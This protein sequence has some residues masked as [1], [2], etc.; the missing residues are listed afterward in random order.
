MMYA[1]YHTHTTFCDGKNTPEEMVLGAIKKGM[2]AIGF[3]GHSYLPGGE[4]YCMLKENIPAYRTEILRLK[5]VY[6]DKIQ[7]LLGLEQEYFSPHTPDG[8][9]YVIG[10]AHNLCKDGK[11][12][13]VD[14]TCEAL[15]QGVNDLF[16][17]D[18]YAAAENYFEIVA[19]IPHKW[20]VDVIGHFDLITKF[21]EGQTLFD[22]SHPRYEKAAKAALD[23]LLLYDIPIEV[24][25]GAMSRGYRT[26]PYPA[27][28][29]LSYIAQKG[30]RV[31]LNGDSH[32]VESLCHRF[33]DVLPM[34]QELGLKVEERP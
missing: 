10:S 11:F 28:K 34:L 29:W 9:D 18:Y 6:G 19:D 21:N 22:E 2:T 25:T 15:V 16:D 26:S 32:S 1:D 20:K 8:Y 30:G 4:S 23:K 13:E 12:C 7:I 33:E 27:K 3:S 14:N 17:G 5:E 24:N 31:I